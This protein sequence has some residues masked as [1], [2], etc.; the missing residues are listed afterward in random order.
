MKIN[1]GKLFEFRGKYFLNSLILIN[2]VL[3]YNLFSRAVLQNQE[4]FH[5]FLISNE[6]L[7]ITL[8]CFWT[9]VALGI[10]IIGLVKIEESANPYFAISLVI[11]YFFAGSMVGKIFLS[12]GIV[13]LI[14]SFIRYAYLAIKNR[15]GGKK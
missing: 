6:Y 7:L 8:G 3:F 14:I 9:M 15:K 5:T 1:W 10:V 12:L 2:L 4:K 11:S 13:I